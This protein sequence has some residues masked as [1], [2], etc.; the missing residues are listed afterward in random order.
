MALPNCA[1]VMDVARL[2]LARNAQYSNLT[3][4]RNIDVLRARAIC[5]EMET[6]LDL[7]PALALAPWRPLVRVVPRLP[8]TEPDRLLELRLAS[9]R[10]VEDAARLRVEHARAEFV[11]GLAAAWGAWRTVAWQAAVRGFADAC[12]QRARSEVIGPALAALAEAVAFE[13]RDRVRVCEREEP[14][15]RRE[16][17]AECARALQRLAAAER[18]GRR[19]AETRR[20][21]RERA[22]AERA[23][24]EQI[25]PP[26]QRPSPTRAEPPAVARESV[27]QRRARARQM[28][29]AASAQR[30]G[31]AARAAMAEPKTADSKACHLRSVVFVKRA[32]KAAKQLRGQPGPAGLFARCIADVDA[33]SRE[34]RA[35]VEAGVQCRG[36]VAGALALVH[37]LAA[38]A[39]QA[40]GPRA[41]LPW[42]DAPSDYAAFVAAFGDMEEA[43]VCLVEDALLSLDGRHC[44]AARFCLTLV[45]DAHNEACGHVGRHRPTHFVRSVALLGLRHVTLAVRALGEQAAVPEVLDELRGALIVNACPSAVIS[46][47]EELAATA[48][49]HIAERQLTLLRTDSVPRLLGA[50]LVDCAASAGTDEEHR[51]LSNTV[52]GT[53]MRFA[54]CT[55]M[56]AGNQ[57]QVMRLCSEWVR[58]LAL[59][60]VAQRGAILAAQPACLAFDPGLLVP[61]RA[62]ALPTAVHRP[63]EVDATSA[64]SAS[65]GFVAVWSTFQLVRAVVYFAI[66]AE[67]DGDAEQLAWAQRHVA[68]VVA[69]MAEV[70]VQLG[71]PRIT[72]ETPQTLRA[73]NGGALAFLPEE[74]FRETTAPDVVFGL[75]DLAPDADEPAFD[76]VPDAEDD[77][78]VLSSDGWLRGHGPSPTLG[79]IAHVFRRNGEGGD[80]PEVLALW[81]AL[82]D[83]FA[84]LVVRPES[85]YG[86]GSA[87]F[88]ALIVAELAVASAAGRLALLERSMALALKMNPLAHKR[89]VERNLAAAA[90]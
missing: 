52:Y 61:A 14:A 78:W 57:P 56:L 50:A 19:R 36:E 43:G 18:D 21:A 8:V 88:A 87:A 9:L 6:V 15:A 20:L 25:R 81:R 66:A 55:E 13:A 42:D 89:R 67:R 4:P 54:V 84:L 76:L 31:A 27:A 59:A 24:L 47:V 65:P 44:D 1:N 32:L 86:P 26:P 5:A 39:L 83:R 7:D 17:A 41:L 51:V 64:C 69:T 49:R 63:D 10:A 85:P 40:A 70:S 22:A 77:R 71:L 79:S 35:D 68:A 80:G 11:E 45:N 29:E 90:S 23:E 60:A 48:R 2:L 53:A 16:V 12:R 46:S 72:H 74:R 34:Y 73:P 82:R 58:V 3:R 37:A 33:L 30:R 75:D 38:V 28:R 62:P